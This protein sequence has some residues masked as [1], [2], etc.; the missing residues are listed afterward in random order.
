MTILSEH[1]PEFKQGFNLWLA[2]RRE[3]GQCACLAGGQW[4]GELDWPLLL[5]EPHTEADLQVE[6]TTLRLIAEDSKFKYK[7]Y[8]RADVYPE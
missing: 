8:V 7:V 2:E 4:F 3:L 6:G 5:G 1:T